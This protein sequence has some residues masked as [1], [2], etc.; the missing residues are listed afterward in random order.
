MGFPGLILLESNHFN[1]RCILV[2]P[3]INHRPTEFGPLLIITAHQEKP[4]TTALGSVNK[5]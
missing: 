2:S 5:R 3:A 1:V 4:L